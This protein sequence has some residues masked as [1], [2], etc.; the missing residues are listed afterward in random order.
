MKVKLEVFYDWLKTFF[1]NYKSFVRH[2][3]VIR[4]C[5][6]G[7]NINFQ[8]ILKILIRHYMSGDALN[9][10]LCS[11]RIKSKAIRIHI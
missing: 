3:E 11:K 8:K 1:V 5:K 9:H 10:C 6:N 2:S 4:A 7:G